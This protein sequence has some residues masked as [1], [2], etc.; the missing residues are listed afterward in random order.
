MSDDIKTHL[1]KLD[2]K[3]EMLID[4]N[5]KQDITMATMAVVLEKNTE[6]LILHEKRTTT[7]EKRQGVIEDTLTR[8]LSFLKGATWL[9]GILFISFSALVKFGVIKL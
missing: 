1:E 9:F 4:L 7:S 6:S 8:H 3:M 5:H 2:D